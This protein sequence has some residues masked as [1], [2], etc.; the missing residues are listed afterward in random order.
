MRGRCG[1]CLGTLEGVTEASESISES[2]KK[3][4]GKKGTTEKF[5]AATSQWVAQGG[6]KS[7]AKAE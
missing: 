6:N 7:R 4:T 1:A 5:F 3:G 2:E